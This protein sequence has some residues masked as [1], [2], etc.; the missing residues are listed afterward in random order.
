AAD[1]V[2][3]AERRRR[4]RPSLAENGLDLARAAIGRMAGEAEQGSLANLGLPAAGRSAA[5]GRP[6]RVDREMADLTAIP[7]DTGER[8]SVDNDPAADA[9]LTG[10][11]HDVVV[12]S[13][14]TS[15][16]LGQCPE[17]GLVGDRDR[18]VRVEGPGDPTPERDVGPLEVRRH[19]H[20]AVRPPDHTDDGH[21][22]ADRVVA[23]PG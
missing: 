3:G 21:A 22:D 18:P 13:G 20:E 19:R 9:D 8:P 12:A 1:A 23:R 10:D 2:E 17:V 14:G 5:A 11:E 16:E 7:G 6:I 4:T 15:P